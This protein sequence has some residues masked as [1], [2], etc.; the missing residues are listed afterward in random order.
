[1]DVVSS[2]NA[3]GA[4]DQQERLDAYVAGFVDGEGCFHVALQRNANT[5][6]GW[7]LVPEFRVSQ[8]AARIQVLHLV[9]ARIG[10]GTLRENHRQS[11]DHTYVLIVRRRRDLLEKVIPFF[12]RN[13]LVSSKQNEASTFARIVR[14]MERGAHREP[15]GFEWLATEALAMNGG[16]RYR[17]LHRQVTIQDPQRPHAEHGALKSAAVK[18]WSD[19]HGD[20][21]SQA[22]MS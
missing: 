15:K 19:L 21:Q 13:P 1:M 5:R 12:E 2:D 20:M 7:Q 17:R 4:V 9:R 3:T 14:A 10:C 22:E 18:I 6:C 16:G 11:H 8:D